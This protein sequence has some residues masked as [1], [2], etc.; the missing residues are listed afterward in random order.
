MPITRKNLVAWA[1]GFLDGEGSIG[2]YMNSGSYRLM[3]SAGQKNNVEPLERLL[4]LFGGTIQNNDYGSYATHYWMISSRQ[5]GSALKEM[6]PF[7]VVKR[8]Q[9]ELAL[10]FQARKQPRG[11][12]NRFSDPK[13]RSARKERDRRDYE[14]MRSLKGRD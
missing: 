11:S 4:A 7:L 13:V 14:L 12:L 2:I 6:L 8:E 5:A 10:E 3:V 9:A 1:A